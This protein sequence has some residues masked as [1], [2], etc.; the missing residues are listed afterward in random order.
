MFLNLE[1]CWVSDVNG[2][3]FAQFLQAAYYKKVK[4]EMSHAF[5]EF[6]CRKW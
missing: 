1:A 5:D 2:G 6:S 4:T 3:G